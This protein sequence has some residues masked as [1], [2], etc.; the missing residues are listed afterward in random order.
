CDPFGL[1][2]EFELKGV[3]FRLRWITPGRF[4]MGSPP[5]ES[6]RLDNEGPVH[7][8]TISRGFWLAET[9]CTQDQWTAVVGKNPSKDK[10]APHPV[11]SVDWHACIDF[12]E[13]L[14]KHIPSLHFRLPTEAEWEYA[15]RAGTQTAFNDGSLCTSPASKDPALE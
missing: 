10:G 11:E 6:G 5:E 9:L 3:V 4:H 14:R 1:Y 8:V 15:C 2:A 12:C 13:R 7:E